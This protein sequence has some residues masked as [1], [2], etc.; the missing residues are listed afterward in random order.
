MHQIVQG[1]CIEV[2]RGLSDCTIDAIVTDPPYG[3]SEQPDMA[4]VLR[5]WLAGDRYEHGSRGF[6]GKTWDSFV[7]GPEYWR[8]CLRVL[9]PGGHL[10]AFA[11]T[12]TYDLM[13]VAVRLGGFEIRDMLD[14][15][16]GTGF[17]KSLNI[18][19]EIDMH[20]CML[21]GRHYDKNLP[22]G[23][24][25]RPEDHLCPEHPAGNAWRGCGNALKPACEP[26]VMARKP[27]IGTVAANVLAHGTGALNIDACRID[28]GKR[29]PGY[30][31]DHDRAAN[32]TWNK[33]TCGYAQDRNNDPNVGRWPAN[34]ILDEEAAVML[35][36]QSGV[37]QSGSRK[38]GVRKGMGFHG[39]DGDGGPAI[40]GSTGGASRFFYVA[41]ASR[42]ER[43]A[44]CEHLPPRTGGEAT[45][46]ED[47]SD[48]LSSPR[49]G[50]GRTGGARNHHPTV[51]PVTLM[52][53]L[54]RMVTPPGG[55][56]L[57]PF[58]G[59]GT[60]G[61]AAV[62]EGFHFLGVEMDPEY[63]RIARLRVERAASNPEEWED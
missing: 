14:W 63:A 44:G 2:L 5:H 58:A 19:R 45:D 18:G 56:V 62:L 28:G 7:P 13:S 55:V 33:E 12:R 41:K 50:A 51:K 27:L 57:D 26:I 46:R 16:Y 60:T 43:D 21:P 40:D 29:S 23:E 10:L 32:A 36:E 22:K 47:G 9:K 59:S 54:V 49:A 42:K 61:A 53:Y 38:A 48:G 20:Q 34:V 24:K 15:L 6:M 4:E 11:A 31:E 8:E 37:L 25:A 1:D 17:P 39:A 3:M 35:D 52:R 30:R